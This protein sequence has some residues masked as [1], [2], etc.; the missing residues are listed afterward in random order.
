[1]VT[2]SS[3]AVFYHIYPLGLCAAPEFNDPAQG[4]VN[5]LDALL[6][7]IDHAAEMGFTALYLGPLF[8]SLSHGYDTSDYFQVD[9]RLG[10]NTDLKSL[11]EYCHNKR[12][13]VVLDAVFNHVGRDFWAFRDVLKERQ[14]S[15]YCAWFSGLNF[16]SNN[17][18]GDGFCYDT[19]D[20]HESLVKLN[21][22]HRPARQYLLDAVHFWISEFDIDGLR[23]DA[24][25]VLALDYQSELAQTCKRLKPDFWLLGEVV[26]GDYNL[27]ANPSGLD[28]VTN[29]E[30]YKG[31]Y[32]S[33]NDHNLFEIAWSLNRQFG[34]EGIY[35]GTSLYNFGDNHDVNRVASALVDKR[36]LVPLYT[37]LF[38]MPGIPSIYYGSEFEVEG[39]KTHSDKPLRPALN[40]GV[41]KQNQNQDFTAFLRKLICLKKT[42][43]ELQ[44][45]DYQQ[46]YLTNEQFAFSR[47]VGKR[48]SIT[49]VNAAD[50][51]VTIDLETN[52]IL[53]GQ[54]LD[55]LD[56][57]FN[58]IVKRGNARIEIPAR[59]ARI[60]LQM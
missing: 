32:S 60:L 51:A 29:Y 44:S 33:F 19:W 2:W 46:L 58:T 28:S 39:V 47:N 45:G 27:W 13:R 24:A 4:S 11:V 43:P 7:W 36:S 5:R 6:P 22:S 57:G 17:Q 8:E 50:Q 9:R 10:T 41:L 31:L 15:P 1:M 3:Q 35:R 25:D 59:T 38:T 23:L 40:L 20:G 16:D 53:D 14:Q 26:H 30:C 21:L 48:S 12:L 54:L 34:P 18:H 56:P 55:A 52:R 42:E 49:C 37:I